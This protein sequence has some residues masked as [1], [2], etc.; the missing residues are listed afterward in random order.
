[1]E[2][3]KKTEEKPAEETPSGSNNILE[4]ARA[5]RKLQDEQLDRREKLIEREEK[6]KSEQILAP[7]GGGGIPQPEETFTEEEQ[8]SR[9]RIKAVADASGSDWGKNY[10]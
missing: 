6:L 5:E 2:E 9:A 1:M 4:L 10:G 7:T 8:K 3:E